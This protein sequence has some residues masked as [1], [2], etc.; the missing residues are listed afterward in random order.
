MKQQPRLTNKYGAW[1]HINIYNVGDIVVHNNATYQNITGG[2]SSPENLTDWLLLEKNE[3]DTSDGIISKAGFSF[4]GEN[5]NFNIGYYW[6]IGGFVY[7]NSNEIAETIPYAAASKTR[8]DYAVGDVNNDIVMVRGAEGEIA[9]APEIPP[10]TIVLERFIVTDSG[11]T[12]PEITE[13]YKLKSESDIISTPMVGNMPSLSLYQDKSHIILLNANSLQSLSINTTNNPYP[14][15]IYTITNNK[16]T[17]ISI[18]NNG[19]TGNVKFLF[20]DGVNYNLKPKESIQ[21][22]L[23]SDLTKL[24]FLSSNMSS[25]T[26]DEHYVFNSIISVTAAASPSYH[27]RNGSIMNLNLNTASSITVPADLVS[28]SGH[29]IDLIIPYNCRLTHVSMVLPNVDSFSLALVNNSSFNPDLSVRTLKQNFTS[30]GANIKVIDQNTESLNI[31]FIQG[32]GIKLFCIASSATPAPKGGYI[33]LT[34]KK[35]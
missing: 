32:H 3:T 18:Y 4:I 5:L 25:A 1:N 2:N 17:P 15:K 10:M 12:A 33:N 7:N 21:F 28:I 13:Q 23:S 20:P 9:Y 6:R 29:I 14:G 34:F 19:G 26:S 24:N 16:T 27:Y 31:N 35:I 8:I 22:F 11:F 30:T